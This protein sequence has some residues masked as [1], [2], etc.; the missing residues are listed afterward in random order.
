LLKLILFY[1]L[2]IIIFRRFIMV[3]HAYATKAAKGT[4]QPFDY[5]P[6][7]LGPWDIEVKITHCGI[8]HSDLHLIDDD[9]ARSQYPLVP[10]HEIV[11]TVTAVGPHVK[12]LKIGQRVGI[13][14]Q[15]SSC[16][17]CEWC[18]EGE[19][20]LC[21]QQEATCLGHKGGFAD[22]IRADSRFAFAIPEKL[23]SEYAAPLMCGGITVFSPLKTH[24]IDASKKVGVIGIGGLGHLALQFAKALGA[25]V[26]A[27]SST[28]TKEQ[29]AKKFGADT[30]VSTADPKNLDKLANSFDL[31]LCTIAAPQDWSIYLDLL[32]PKGTLCFVGAQT[33]PAEIPVFTLIERRK[34]VDGSNIGNRHE[35]E[36]MLE[37]ASSHGIKPQIELFP[38]HELNNALDKLRKNNIRYRAVLKN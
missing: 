21:A 5:N 31:I 36:E 34:G 17:N 11:G 24:K 6:D 26:T 15:R 37:F 14:W 33:K 38:M 32:R 35:I 30:F 25:K 1:T 23:A 10:G 7:E 27:F 29:E 3:I 18:K 9:W 22:L 13:G 28:P 19:E 2:A 20:N 4:L 12:S 8:C 16:L